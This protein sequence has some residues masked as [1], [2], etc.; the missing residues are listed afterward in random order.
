MP[1]TTGA[2]RSLIRELFAGRDYVKRDSI[3]EG[4]LQTHT[5]KGGKDTPRKKVT[6]A[7]KKVLSELEAEGLAERHPNSTGYWKIQQKTQTSVSEES[8]EQTAPAPPFIPNASERF[9]ADLTDLAFEAK[10]IAARATLLESKAEALAA[11]IKKP[12]A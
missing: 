1:L 2:A 8:S 5:K 12:T 10:E 4:I 7:V 11:R 3:V 6:P 9:E